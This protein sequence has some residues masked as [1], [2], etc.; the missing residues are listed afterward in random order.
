ML[1]VPSA[2]PRRQRPARRVSARL[3]GMPRKKWLREAY[4]TVMQRKKWLREDEKVLTF[5]FVEPE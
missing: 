1:E 5:N 2:S 4:G 3:E